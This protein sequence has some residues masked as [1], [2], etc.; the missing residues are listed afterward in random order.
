MDKQYHQVVR[1]EIDFS[2]PEEEPLVP[3]QNRISR[4]VKRRLSAQLDAL[5][6][7]FSDPGVSVKLDR[8]E[9]DVGSILIE[10]LERELPQKLE[11]ELRKELLRLQQQQGVLISKRALS[12]E[13]GQRKT[14]QGTPAQIRVQSLKILQV[15]LEK[16]SFPWWVPSELAQHP[17]D[18][19]QQLL[20]SNTQELKALFLN[21]MGSEWTR[22]RIVHNFKD[23]DLKQVVKL[24]EP[25]YSRT[26]INYSDGLANQHEKAPIVKLDHR[27][28]RKLRWELILKYLYEERGSEFNQKSFLKQILV[29][30]A[31]RF[32]I[33]YRELVLKLESIALKFSANNQ[34][35]ASLVKH[36]L[37]LAGEEKSNQI[38]QAQNSISKPSQSL[39]KNLNPQQQEIAANYL[40]FI[41]GQEDHWT[42]NTKD[43][44]IA[45]LLI[46]R[47]W[48][49]H[50][51]K[52]IQ[53]IKRLAL[54]GKSTQALLDRL[55][56]H[57]IQATIAQLEP[58]LHSELQHL[59]SDLV[60]LA[61]YRR[62]PN[63]SPSTLQ[64]AIQQF[65]LRFLSLF[66]H[67]RY[68]ISVLL[69][70]LLKKIADKSG[71]TYQQLMVELLVSISK[72]LHTTTLQSNIVIELHQLLKEKESAYHWPL[73]KEALTTAKNKSQNAKADWVENNSSIQTNDWC[74]APQEE[75]I[76]SYL[77]RIKSWLKEKEKQ[78]Y[79]TTLFNQP[80]LFHQWLP[81]LLKQWSA[82]HQQLFLRLLWPGLFDFILNW[83]TDSRTLFKLTLQSLHIDPP[84]N[85]S[86][87][88]AIWTVLLNSGTGGLQPDQLIG[89][90]LRIL[91]QQTTISEAKLLKTFH[92]LAVAQ[93]KI[94]KLG[95]QLT[96]LL[97]RAIQR[98]LFIYG[99]SM[100]LNNTGEATET[101]AH[102]KAI[103]LYFNKGQLPPG[104]TMASLRL[105]FSDL[106]KSAP[107][108]LRLWLWQAI[109]LAERRERILLF[110]SASSTI[111]LMDLLHPQAGQYA[112]GVLNII[113]AKD[114]LYKIGY[115]GSAEKQYWKLIWEVLNDQIRK[116]FQPRAYVETI[117][118]TL[119]A[120]HAHTIAV[121]GLSTVDYLEQ[122]GQITP[123]DSTWRMIKIVIRGM[124]LNARRMPGLKMTKEQ[125][126]TV[127][128]KNFSEMSGKE[129]ILWMEQLLAGRLYL[130]PNTKDRTTDV[131][132]F[133]QH[134]LQLP[135]QEKKAFWV[136]FHDRLVLNLLEELTPAGD[137][138][139]LLDITELLGQV[140]QK[141]EKIAHR[142]FPMD[143]SML[144]IQALLNNRGSLSNQKA[145]IHQLLK[146]W[147]R[148]HNWS[149]QTLV[150]T[151]WPLMLELGPV[152]R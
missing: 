21:I 72:S 71:W 7:A 6:S 96:K 16:G 26:I 29:D 36:I 125:S 13:P 49:T 50:P 151:L 98:K 122:W 90:S 5:F 45:L 144:L 91:A 106:L 73:S 107:S 15:Y 10:D 88:L 12:I 129:L 95:E 109:R 34:K 56:N 25:V 104:E 60:K 108:Q 22:R 58:K 37:L 101:A 137:L 66:A 80:H 47:C 100:K 140:A 65:Y 62:L 89:E 78:V 111:E 99:D 84:T 124:N 61:S 52:A 38:K 8:L 136:L 69:K 24:L 33:T 139:Q 44:H 81:T 97:A 134:L 46:E 57:I 120:Q 75:S 133:S 94:L 110:F 35:E 113:R 70:A 83:T 148:A 105:I 145:F 150:E 42:V 39:L 117:I 127:Q 121:L 116:G 48:A 135:Q 31:T 142:F 27:D 85:P 130:S 132:A 119:L 43:Q 30:L 67:Q 138:P 112:L 141:K 17:V 79:R 131:L 63:W 19:F 32:N 86:I 128:A 23:P 92:S 126:T 147:A 55:P 118:Q 87:E 54:Q 102:F 114:H 115:T 1:F 152:F 149:Y 11:E 40:P 123:E 20:Q 14:S 28:F 77:Q 53:V 4:L 9:L 146:D 2:L 103:D 3:I 76:A 74:F 18:S 82:A 93:A 64:K 143:L 51:H 41:E 59:Q 68:P